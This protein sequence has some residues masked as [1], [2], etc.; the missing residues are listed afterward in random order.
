M[1]LVLLGASPWG[2]S[3]QF[4]V[5]SFF[6]NAPSGAYRFPVVANSV[7]PACPV[8]VPYFVSFRATLGGG[9]PPYSYT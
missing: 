7:L 1:G 3:Q 2:S 4:L 9:S 5:A 8:H 6:A